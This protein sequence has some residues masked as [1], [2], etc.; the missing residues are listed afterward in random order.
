MVVASFGRPKLLNFIIGLTAISIAS[1]FTLY[2]YFY[3]VD[4][5]SKTGY[6][7]IPLVELNRL[8]IFFSLIFFFGIIGGY[9]IGIFVT[10]KK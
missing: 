6:I 8:F 7:D 3:M 1:G 10:S 2:L 9:W 5:A 4:F